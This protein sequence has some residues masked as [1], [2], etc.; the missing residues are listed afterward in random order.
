MHDDDEPPCEFFI[1][2]AF[3][4]KLIRMIGNTLVPSELGVTASII[5]LDD[6]EDAQVELGLSKCKYWFDNVVTKTIAF[7]R[8]NGTAYSMLIDDD[9]EVRIGNVFM[10][11]PDDPRDE[12]LGAVFQ[13]KMN[14]LAAGAFIVETVTVE[15][16]NLNGISF[17]LAGNHASYLPATMDDWLGGESFFDVPWWH[18]DDASTL[19]VYLM[20]EAKKDT[21]PSWAFSLDFLDKSKITMKP[22][23]EK[24]RIVHA[25]K[26]TIIK[27]GK[28]ED[29]E[30]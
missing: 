25:F 17:M 13:A 27:G 1:T 22:E 20:D 28:G 9:G 2:Y 16:D 15:S 11:V 26:P 12:L 21:K 10:M 14:A 5:R 18:R 3:D 19:D 24:A 6:V 23:E 29:E 8:D 30:K 4:V 7:A